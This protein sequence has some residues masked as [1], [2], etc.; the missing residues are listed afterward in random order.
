MA[1]ARI[2]IST[3]AGEIA[4]WQG[5]H[6]AETAVLLHGGPGLSDYLDS[7]SPLLGARFRTIRYQQR[8]L[9]P[10]TVGAPYTVESNVADAVAVIDEAGGG[11]AWIVGHSWGGHLALHMLV[12]CPERLAGV[13]IVDPLGAHMDVLEEF[14]E[15]LRHGLD[16]AQL[17]RLDELAA[18]EQAGQ[19]G[20]DPE[21]LRIVW[22]NYFADPAAAPPMPAMR[23]SHDAHTGTFA[24]IVDH[25]AAGTL[26]TGLPRVPATLPVV[27]V[28]GAQSPLPA[29]ATTATAALI[30]HARVVRIEA[31]G[32]LPWLERP[33]ECI[34]PLDMDGRTS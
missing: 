22:P 30:P 8:G 27:F 25:A 10:T 31:A 29:A 7:L 18:L 15:N 28:Y 2:S 12:A 17:R 13:V 3:P 20:D 34:A 11:R 5:G 19:A 6:G 1:E 14:G 24:S 32:H 21:G 33:E 16:P 23:Q 26:T 9:A 4:G